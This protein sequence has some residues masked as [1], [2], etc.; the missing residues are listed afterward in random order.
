MLIQTPFSHITTEKEAASVQSRF[1]AATARFRLLRFL[2]RKENAQN[3]DIYFVE[4]RTIGFDYLSYIHKT[5]IIMDFT[6]FTTENF[7]LNS[8]EYF[9]PKEDDFYVEL[10][11]KNAEKVEL[12]LYHIQPL[13]EN[14]LFA[15]YGAIC[16]TALLGNTLV[17]CLVIVSELSCKSIQFL[18]SQKLDKFVVLCSCSHQEECGR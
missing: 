1:C 9:I 6:E 17:L 16:A 14:I 10:S 3:V 8:S 5:V 2:L 15:S 12:K 4:A 11:A 13:L 7:T 18:M